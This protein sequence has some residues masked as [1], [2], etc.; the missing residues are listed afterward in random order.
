ML[1]GLNNC[2]DTAMFL[3]PTLR[4]VTSSASTRLM[5]VAEGARTRRGFMDNTR[6]RNV[7]S[8][9]PC[10]RSVGGG[11]GMAWGV[12]RIMQYLKVPVTR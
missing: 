7:L 12:R 3:P 8:S 4:D 6:C 2:S 1:R 11:V 9:W 5:H 10:W